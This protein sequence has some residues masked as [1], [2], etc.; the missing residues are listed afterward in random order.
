MQEACNDNSGQRTKGRHRSQLELPERFAAA[1]DCAI[2]E[3]GIWQV[4]VLEAWVCEVQLINSLQR[5]KICRIAPMCFR[6]ALDAA[7]ESASFA[8]FN[9]SPNLMR[10]FGSTSEGAS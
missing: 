1:L 8:L 10:I 5:H 7:S 4:D 2:E 9:R 3:I 6:A